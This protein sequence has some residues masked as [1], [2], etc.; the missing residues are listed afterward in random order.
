M[1]VY[2]LTLHAYRS[3]GP[4]NPRGYVYHSKGLLPPDPEMAKRYNA[5]AKFDKVEFEKEIQRLLIRES[6]DICVRRGWRLHAI[7]NEESHLH[8]LI[9]WHGFVPYQQ[10]VAQM[11]GAL[12]HALG[13]QIGPAGRKW[14]ARG[15]S[16]RRVVDQEYFD[17]LVE[18]YFPSHRGL[19]WRE[20]DSLP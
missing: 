11:K 20:G 3:W 17:H 4:D 5:R 12:S 7:G 1:P 9:S 18:T 15:A 6:H 2:H 13:Q 16:E 10:I 14:F 19:F 8:Q